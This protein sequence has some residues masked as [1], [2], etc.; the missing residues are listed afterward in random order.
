M[1]IK[2]YTGRMGSG[3]TYEVV[4][5]VIL[6]ALSRGRRVVSNIAGLKHDAIKKL[7]AAEGIKNIGDLVQINHDDVVRPSFWLSDDN[8]DESF[9]KPGDLLV[10]DEVWRFW[11][12]FMSSRK[13]PACVMNFFRMH[14]HFTHSETGVSCDVV[15]ITQDVMDISRSVRSVVEETYNMTKLT[16][17]GL[18]R[19]YRVDIYSGSRV[20][21]RYPYKSLQRAYDKRYFPLY[22]SHSQKKEGDADAKEENID[23]RGNILKGVFFKIIIPCAF[24]MFIFCAVYLW[25]L[26]HPEMKKPAKQADKKSAQVVSS[27]SSISSAPSPVSRSV[28]FF[29]KD[30]ISNISLTMRPRLVFWSNDGGK[31][32]VMIE[33]RGNDNVNSGVVRYTDESLQAM[34]WRVFVSPDGNL[35]ILTNGRESFVIS[36]R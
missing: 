15:L 1:S 18:A 25:N 3:K 6:S 4:S 21:G 2:V 30:Y 20:S 33:W 32:R 7:L 16:S 27:A 5:V 17:L 36:S 24:I 14:R 11:D 26:F 35:A 23:D 19:R 10:L 13:M 22:S 9:L 28:D 34:G 12:G 31:S 29:P 8:K